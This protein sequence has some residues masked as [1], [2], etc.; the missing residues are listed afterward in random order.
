M[1]DSTTEIAEAKNEVLNRLND[2]I[3]EAS[4]TYRG[5]VQMILAN[6]LIHLA[7]SDPNVRK[8]EYFFP[9]GKMRITSKQ[10]KKE[11]A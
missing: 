9:G 2:L 1:S 8:A 10:P 7:M 4:A 3:E 6:R 5:E 11:G